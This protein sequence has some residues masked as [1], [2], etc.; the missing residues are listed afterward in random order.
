MFNVSELEF[1]VHEQHLGLMGLNLHFKPSS[2]PAG[3]HPVSQS[4]ESET[5]HLISRQFANLRLGPSCQPR[6]TL[7]YFIGKPRISL[8][9]DLVRDSTVALHHLLSGGTATCQTKRI[10]ARSVD[11]EESESEHPGLFGKCSARLG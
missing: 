10:S 9:L 7:E 3:S 11:S 8:V 5:I 2:N 4:I 1:I 6:A